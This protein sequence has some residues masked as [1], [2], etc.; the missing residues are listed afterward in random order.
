V[1]ASIRQGW[2]GEAEPS[3]TAQGPHDRAEGGVR[4]AQRSRASG[5]HGPFLGPE[6]G[7][8]KPR[9]RGVSHQYAA[10]VAS[11]AGVA[12]VAAS[13]TPAARVPLA[14]YALA[15]VGLFAI[16]ALYHRVTWTPTARKRVRCLDHGMILVLIAG[17]ATPF[18]VLVL[19]PG[20]GSAVLAIAWT[21]ALGGLALQVA[22]GAAPK[23][24]T[25]L[26]CVALGWAA[27]AILP[28]LWSTLG[29][30]AVMLLVGG[31]AVYTLGAVVY[32]LRRPDPA[33]AVF[34]YHE[35]FHA[36][37]IAAAFLHFVA[38]ASS[39]LPRA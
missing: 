9:L 4:H 14:V 20:V 12:L 1:R 24:I 22:W 37:V 2:P 35:V 13:P 32:A 28:T 31:G 23:W 5:R 26:V 33:P 11:A 34:G 19:P 16:S 39:L 3:Q 27:L 30:R 18:A 17:T 29:P 10:L 38:I 21:V 15:L 8:P 25:A 7:P 6:A 36:L